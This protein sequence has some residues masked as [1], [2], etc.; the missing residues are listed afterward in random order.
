MLSR[1]APLAA[2]LLL[3]MQAPPALADGSF[4]IAV[5]GIVVVAPEYEGAKD[6]KVMG[7]PIAFPI[8]ASF[9]ADG[10]VQ[11]R[12]IDDLRLRLL[13]ASG[14]EAGPLVG[15]RF[16]REEDDGDRLLGLGDVD[17]GLVVGGYAGYRFGA[18]MPFVSYHH[19][20]TGD[21]TGGVLRFGAEAK[22]T[23]AYGITATVTGGA[24]YADDEYMD[25][26][27][28]VS[29]AQSARSVAGL[30]VYDAEAGIKD[31]FIGFSGDVPID[32]RWSVKVSGRYAHIIGDAADSAI[33]E[34]E[35]Q[36]SGGLGLTY[37]FSVGR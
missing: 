27:F 23:L 34:Q 25:A 24:T 9:G 36:F 3:L 10:M 6:Y 18:F 21:D 14:F 20:V 12:G 29:G 5:G 15:W 30:G 37:R 19:Q 13:N 4:D 11:F 2:A 7:A 28:S 17:G 26:Y 8:G 33:V 35:S 1:H 32:D 16:D 22:T 31:V